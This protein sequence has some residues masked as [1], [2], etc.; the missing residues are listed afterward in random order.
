MSIEHD[1][2]NGEPTTNHPVDDVE[3]EDDL[4]GDVGDG[5]PVLFRIGELPNLARSSQLR[6]GHMLQ[7]SISPKLHVLNFKDHGSDR[8]RTSAAHHRLQALGRQRRAQH[9]HER[10][11]LQAR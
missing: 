6:L 2:S 3:S 10:L 9:R 7:D 11:E 1:Q 8:S 5:K 4:N